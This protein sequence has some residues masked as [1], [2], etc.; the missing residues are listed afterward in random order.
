MLNYLIILFFIII[1][2]LFLGVMFDLLLMLEEIIM[3]KLT[4]KG[5]VEQIV[6]Y[7]ENK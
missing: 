5:I 1:D 7:L 6:E 3:R 2:V 4:G